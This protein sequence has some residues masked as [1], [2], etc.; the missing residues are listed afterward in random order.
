[1]RTIL[2]RRDRARLEKWAA[3]VTNPLRALISLTYDQDVLVRWRAIEAAGWVSAT[4]AESNLDKVR[5]TIRRLLWLMNDESGGLGW[6]NPELIGEMLCGVPSLIPEFATLL[7]SFLVEEPFEAG[8]HWAMVRLADV[9]PQA[10]ADAAPKV[11]R[12]LND[13]NPMIRA[14]AARFLISIKAENLEAS[15]S[16]LRTDPEEFQLY[17]LEKGELT[18]VPVGQ[19]VRDSLD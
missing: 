7:P 2:L 9:A 10:V 4:L 15:I 13:P 1:M 17:D 14:L 16:P 5:D 18:T 11:A 19:Y 8:T 6:Y 3:A 12:S